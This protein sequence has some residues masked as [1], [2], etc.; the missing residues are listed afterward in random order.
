[1]RVVGGRGFESG[2]E[3]NGWTNKCPTNKKTKH[4]QGPIEQKD[5][6]CMQ[7]SY[8]IDAHHPMLRHTFTVAPVVITSNDE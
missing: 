1:V 7:D 4:I 5:G 2:H 6:S 8:G 3:L